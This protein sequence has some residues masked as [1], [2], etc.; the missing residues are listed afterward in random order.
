MRYIYDAF[1]F[2]IFLFIFIL[3]IKV[4]MC[5]ANYVGK[6]IGFGDIFIWIWQKIRKR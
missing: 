5:V 4:Y 6:K 3:I 1:G 2:L